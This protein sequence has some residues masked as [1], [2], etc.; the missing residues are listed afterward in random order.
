MATAAITVSPAAAA[1]LN[2]ILAQHAGTHQTA[3]L[4]I[5]VVA[6]GCSGYQYRLALDHSQV[7]DWVSEI[8]GVRVL[9]APRVLPF[10]DGAR[11]E[12]DPGA[13]GFRIENPNVDYSCGCGSSF[14]LRD[15][16]KRAS[17]SRS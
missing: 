1:H 4:R 14:Q 16:P 17:G 13:G 11:V 9:V 15:A 2:G 3:G 12:Y 8:A 5:D 10:V 6:G 7:A